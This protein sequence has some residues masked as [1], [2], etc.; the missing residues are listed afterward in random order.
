MEKPGFENKLTLESTI[1]MLF[2]I[3]LF[4]RDDIEMSVAVYFRFLNSMGLF[5]VIVHV[6]LSVSPELGKLT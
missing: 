5:A 4:H 1:T 3:Q 2:I 6:E